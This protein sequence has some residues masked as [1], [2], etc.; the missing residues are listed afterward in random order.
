MK[1]A[2]VMAAALAV[3]AVSAAYAQQPDVRP[4]PY[5]TSTKDLVD[6]LK[7]ASDELNRK[8]MQERE[9]RKSCRAEARARKIPL[10]KRR[11]FMRSCTAS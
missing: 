3:V 5:T 10:M 11:Q 8:L 4:A 9:K 1:Q 6:Q 7:R 2:I